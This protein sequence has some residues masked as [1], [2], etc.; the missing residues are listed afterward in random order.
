MWLLNTHTYSLKLFVSPEAVS[1]PYAIL[2]HCWGDKEQSFQDLQRI[3]EQCAAS[4]TDPQDLLCAKI[5]GC[6]RL[7]RSHGYEWVWIDT[8]CI[9]KTSSAE[10]SE[11]INSMYRYYSLADVCYA[12]LPDVPPRDTRDLGAVWSATFA[13]SR[14][15][16]RGWTLQEL[17]APKMVFLLSNTWDV[18][19]SKADL[20]GELEFVT[21]IPASVLRHEARPADICVAQRMSWAA[22]RETTRVEDQAYCL[23]GLFGVN[24]PT[25]YGEGTN[26]Y[27]RLQ[28]EIMRTSVDTT[29]FAWQCPSLT[30][31]G[32][33]V[34]LSP[35]S[36]EATGLL[37]TEPAQFASSGNVSYTPAIYKAVPADLTSRSDLDV[38]SFT[39]TPQ[40]IRARLPVITSTGRVALKIAPLGW[41]QRRS[42]VA[43]NS[44]R[45]PHSPPKLTERSSVTVPL[46]MV[47]LPERTDRNSGLGASLPLYSVS[48]HKRGHGHVS[49]PVRA[50]DYQAILSTTFWGPESRS[51]DGQVAHRAPSWETVYL[52]HTTR[53]PDPVL[54]TPLRAPMEQAC[55]APVRI[56]RV[57]W[58]AA[59]PLSVSVVGLA[60]VSDMPW[61]GDPPARVTIRVGRTAPVVPLA[62]SPPPYPYHW[63]QAEVQLVLQL[64][65]CL[66]GE[67]DLSPEARSRPVW[68]NV[69]LESD[70]DPSTAASESSRQTHDC[71]TDHVLTW[72]NLEKSFALDLDHGLPT[73]SGVA[74]TF[75]V[76]F[77]FG[78]CRWNPQQSLELRTVGI[79][80]LGISASELDGSTST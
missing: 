8:C 58:D 1:S 23:L 17:I 12:Y 45:R 56:S 65:R 66:A 70:V 49:M 61:E 69:Q 52:V 14:W 34:D 53:A 73:Y 9:D 68:A 24:M 35:R 71:P 55:D 16:K 11:A 43:A 50:A 20:A 13:W 80:E 64:G 10:L 27:R 74:R 63:H 5:T 48:R 54:T 19:G 44:G 38:I 32:W 4:G 72:P 62:S 42:E 47:L 2:S 78:R 29:L 75:D 67:C 60:N 33:N 51:D 79:C 36:M 3:H 39:T 37:A 28:E 30:P 76:R 7:V 22:S 31:S 46:F 41:S 15:H 26:A 40:G 25:L 21:G 18:L 77:E 57:R 59:V 6:C